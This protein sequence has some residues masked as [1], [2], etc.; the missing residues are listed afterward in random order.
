MEYLCKICNVCVE[1]KK[2]YKIVLKIDEE[3]CWWCVSGNNWDWYNRF[4]ILDWEEKLLYF[5]YCGLFY[6]MDWSWIFF[7]LGSSDCCVII[8]W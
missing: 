3:I 7:R 5:N 1:R 6:K 4:V 2:V 8:Y